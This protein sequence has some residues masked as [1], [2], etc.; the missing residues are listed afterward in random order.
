[1]VQGVVGE[2]FF[3]G[4]RFALTDSVKVEMAPSGVLLK[5]TGVDMMGSDQDEAILDEVVKILSTQL[6]KDPLTKKRKKSEDPAQKISFKAAKL[7]KESQAGARHRLPTDDVDNVDE[8][9]AVVNV[10]EAGSSVQER[11]DLAKETHRPKTI[12]PRTAEAMKSTMRKEGDTWSIGA[13][14]MFVENKQTRQKNRA[15]ST[16]SARLR[17]WLESPAG[18]EWAEGRKELNNPSS[19]SQRQ[20][21]QDEA[22]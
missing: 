10:V 12:D 4:S 6:H 2:G 21:Q 8:K 5:D 14:P 7:L 3:S 20:S 19:L 9:D 1:M 15:P 18:K 16:L 13:L 22:E 17:E 11:R